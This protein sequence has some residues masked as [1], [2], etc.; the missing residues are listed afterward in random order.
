MLFKAVLKINI[1]I[2]TVIRDILHRNEINS[3]S[4]GFFAKEI[5]ELFFKWVTPLKNPTDYLKQVDAMFNLFEK[6]SKLIAFPYNYC[7]SAKLKLF[8]VQIVSQ[9]AFYETTYQPYPNLSVSGTYS[10]STRISEKHE[11]K[12]DFPHTFLTTRS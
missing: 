8:W 3:M 2:K 4:A 1:T 5:N 11:N 6:T 7:L 10:S 9:L 12:N